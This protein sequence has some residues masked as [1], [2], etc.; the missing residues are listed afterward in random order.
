[1][2][3]TERGL[4]SCL[5]F[6]REIS[7]KLNKRPFTRPGARKVR[8]GPGRPARVC[9]PAAPPAAPEPTSSPRTQAGTPAEARRRGCWT[10]AASR[11]LPSAGGEPGSG[12]AR[13]GGHIFRQAP[14]EVRERGR[15]KPSSLDFSQARSTSPQAHPQR[16]MK[17]RPPRGR[18]A[19]GLLAARAPR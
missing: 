4:P 7:F 15:R 16:K 14:K 19:P 9:L 18:G 6:L 17:T 10:P 3:F 12:N 5:C 13:T 1:M 2:R 8:A 11:G